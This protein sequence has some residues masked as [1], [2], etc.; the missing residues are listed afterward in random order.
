MRPIA[1]VG[2]A[3][4]ALCLT[5]G[6]SAAEDLFIVIK[7]MLKDGTVMPGAGQTLKKADGQVSTKA[8]EYWQI[9]VTRDGLLPYMILFGPDPN[10]DDTTGTCYIRDC[11]ASPQHQELVVKKGAAYFIGSQPYG[12]SDGGSGVGEGTKF[13]VQVPV[14]DDT[15]TFVYLD[16][17]D[18]DY[19]TVY[20]ATDT[21][22][23]QSITEIN[24]YSQVADSGAISGTVPPPTRNLPAGDP[25]RTGLWKL[26]VIV[27][28]FGIE[29]PDPY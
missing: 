23:R 25:I 26:V 2:A 10:A 16:E 5:H 27:D 13:V 19:M 7:K 15:A 28:L 29:K 20:N 8:N 22:E 12:A 17:D 4:A 3:V 1:F 18:G 21:R 9:L 14:A 11:A 24:H 6:A